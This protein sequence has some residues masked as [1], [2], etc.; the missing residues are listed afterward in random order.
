MPDLVSVGIPLTE[1]FEGLSGTIDS[2]F[3]QTYD[4]FEIVLVDDFGN[5]D[6]DN[7]ARTLAER[8][9]RIVYIKTPGHFGILPSHAEAL[10]RSKGAY[11]MWVGVG[12][13]LEPEFLS[14]CVDRLER[15]SD[16][17]LVVGSSRGG[18]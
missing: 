14:A 9:D 12:D 6:E 10:A 3:S 15:K 17:S 1:T 2:L 18:G 4:A 16:L 7:P 8:D 13:T 5:D 11:F